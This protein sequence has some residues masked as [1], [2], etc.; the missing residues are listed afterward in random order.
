[1]K[2]KKIS[3]AVLLSIMVTSFIVLAG[4]GKKET[5]TGTWKSEDGSEIVY[6]FNEDG[7][8]TS[9]LGGDINMS[10]SYSVNEDKLTIS[11]EILG[12]TSDT[13]YTYLL[14]KG[15]LTLTNGNSTVNFQKQ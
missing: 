15:K 7:T 1:M 3:V 11:K 12:T 9:S 6:V 13:T 14:E 4:C 8:G 5:L 10:I 2:N